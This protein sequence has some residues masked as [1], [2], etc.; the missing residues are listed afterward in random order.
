MKGSVN[1]ASAILMALAMVFVFMPK[2]S[3]PVY[4]DNN[5]EWKAEL[6]AKAAFNN[7]ESDKRYDNGDTIYLN[8]GQK[9][10]VAFLT[11]DD[12]LEHGLAPIV[13]WHDTI[14]DE[15][16]RIIKSEGDLSK[17]GFNVK[18]GSVAELGYKGKL[19]NVHGD[20]LDPD[21]FSIE[22]EAG[23]MQPG[24]S[25]TLRYFL[26]PYEGADFWGDFAT[27]KFSF[28]N[29]P[30][31]EYTYTINVKIQK[32][33]NPLTMKPKTPTV[34][35]SK[36]KNKTQTLAV[37]KV[38]EF[39]KKTNDKKNYTLSSVKKGKKSFRKYFKINKTT[40]RVTVK[41]GLK[42][43]SYKVKVKVKAL[44]NSKYKASAVKTVTFTVKVK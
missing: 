40:G 36:L 20:D 25:G 9:V 18:S 22:I 8:P 10:C 15:N 33:A 28:S 14:T 4:A 12:N 38:I 6:Y 19:K 17:L 44:G 23:K 29:K 32:A 5:D 39:T 7:A 34:K 24:E 21:Y 41:K 37:T 35:Y 42:K 27:G 30:S 11:G 31:E 1:R 16:G 26:Y 13:G 43:G 3:G 2:T